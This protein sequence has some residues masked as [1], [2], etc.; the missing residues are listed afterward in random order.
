MA[1]NWQGGKLKRRMRKAQ[2]AG[3]DTTMAACILHAKASHG[4]GAHSAQRFETQTGSLERSIRI[5]QAARETRDGARGLWGSTDT[6]YALRIEMGFQGQDAKGRVVDA[7]AFPY[8]RPAA[9]AEYPKLA[10]RIRRAL[11]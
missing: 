10:G 3:V 2:K 5:V 9:D 4:P 8:L 7:P 6:A 1:L 11:A